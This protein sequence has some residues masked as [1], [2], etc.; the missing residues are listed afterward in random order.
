MV[1][2]Y[3]LQGHDGGRPKE[4]DGFEPGPPS[5]FGGQVAC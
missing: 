3:V 4:E 1:E 5:S 2:A